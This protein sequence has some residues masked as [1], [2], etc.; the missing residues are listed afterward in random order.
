VDTFFSTVVCAYRFFFFSLRCRCN[1]HPCGSFGDPKRECRCTPN[2]LRPYRQRL[3]GP[4]LERIDIH[5][6]VPAVEFRDLNRA[7]SGEP[8]DTIRARIGVA[9]AVQ[10]ARFAREPN[11]RCN[12][13]MSSRVMKAHT[14]LDDPGHAHEPVAY[15][16]LWH[17]FR[18]QNRFAGYRGAHPVIWPG[19]PGLDAT[20]GYVLPSR[21]DGEAPCTARSLQGVGRGSRGVGRGARVVGRGARG[22]GRGVR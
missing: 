4:L 14:A 20:H 18:V 7:D 2:Q 5:I 3:S 22:V 1:P 13:A 10:A 17:P 9:R 19:G 12:A 16:Y 11:I 6:E 15:A 21:W 8:S